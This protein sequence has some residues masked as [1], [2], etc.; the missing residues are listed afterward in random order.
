[1]NISHFGTHCIPFLHSILQQIYELFIIN[2]HFIDE[3]TDTGGK[4]WNQDLNPALFLTLMCHCRFQGA[5]IPH[6]LTFHFLV[7]SS[8]YSNV[9]VVLVMS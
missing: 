9:S 3:V 8:P 7:L 4:Y 6:L 2:Y 5:P 1:M